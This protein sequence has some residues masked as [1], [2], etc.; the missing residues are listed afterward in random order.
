MNHLLDVW[1]SYCPLLFYVSEQI[2]GTPLCACRRAK[3]LCFSSRVPRSA[4]WRCVCLS[5][6]SRSPASISC[7]AWCCAAWKRGI[8][9]RTNRRRSGS[10]WR[11][12]SSTTLCKDLTSPWDPAWEIT[13]TN[14]HYRNKANASTSCVFSPTC[15]QFSS[16]L[17]F[18]LCVFFKPWLM[19]SAFMEMDTQWAVAWCYCF[20]TRLLFMKMNQAFKSWKC[21][22][23]FT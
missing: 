6:W 9:W 20:K 19:G 10:P 11:T 4:S 7:T 1:N 3:P 14:A 21:N 16:Q 23:D 12:G 15:R 18:R 13:C 17:C 22:T 5:S 2:L 8:T